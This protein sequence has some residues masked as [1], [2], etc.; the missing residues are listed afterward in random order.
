MD[1]GYEG[2]PDPPDDGPLDVDGNPVMLREMLG[3]LIDN[4]IRYTPDGG[5]IAVRVRARPARLVHLEVEDT[6]P[7]IP[8]AERERVVESVSTGSSAAKA[9]AAASGRD[10]ARD[11]HAA[12]RH[13]DA[14]RSRLP[15]RTAPRRHARA[16]QPAAGRNRPGL[17]LT[18]A[19]APRVESKSTIYQTIKALRSTMDHKATDSARI[20]LQSFCTRESV[21]RKFRTNNPRQARPPKAAAHLRD[22][23]TTHGN[24]RRAIS[25]SP[26]T[27]EEK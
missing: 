2:P 16:R 1:L 20:N 25:H 9:T 11:R 26:M 14:R 22:L 5:R 3:N 21:G 8:A 10:R 12:R 6:G 17:T 13:T 18:G 7:G 23:E 27:G 15:A 24:V 19:A 4:A